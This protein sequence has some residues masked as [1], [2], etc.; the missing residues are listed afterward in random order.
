MTNL[1]VVLAAE[2]PGYT[3]DAFCLAPFAAGSVTGKVVVCERGG[4]AAASR[5][6]TSPARAVRP[7]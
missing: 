1:P 2:P 4:A 5:R 3:G 6:A 7:A